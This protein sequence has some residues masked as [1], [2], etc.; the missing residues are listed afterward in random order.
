MSGHSFYDE[1]YASF[2][3]D[4]QAAVNCITQE[5]FEHDS[6][7]SGKV[8][9]GK[10]YVW[11]LFS[12][13]RLPG[14]FIELSNWLETLNSSESRANI[15][16]LSDGST[17]SDFVEQYRGIPKALDNLKKYQA[18]LQKFSLGELEEKRELIENVIAELQL[19][20]EAVRVHLSKKHKKRLGHFIVPTF[21]C[22]V[23]WRRTR[24]N[25]GDMDDVENKTKRESTYYCDYHHPQKHDYNNA[26][27]KRALLS[28]ISEHKESHCHKEVRQYLDKEIELV[29][30]APFL[31]RCFKSLVPEKR[32][33]P[34][35]LE[36][37]GGN[38]YSLAKLLVEHLKQSC[39]TVHKKIHAID[40]KD[41][42]NWNDWMIDGVIKSLDEK[43]VGYWRKCESNDWLE[44][45]DWKTLLKLCLR[46]EVYEAVMSSRNGVGR[47]SVVKI[48]KELIGSFYDE[49]GFVP[50]TKFIKEKT[51][52]S[53]PTI[54][55]AKREFKQE[56]SLLNR[57]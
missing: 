36:F 32:Y 13:V 45:N 24:H 38:W 16:K 20:I 57:N 49:Y 2:E 27:A 29:R 50:K 40:S 4:I 19:T 3:R 17:I 35:L 8:R 22:A 25:L 54:A 10:D 41:Y 18:F 23:C 30:L 15:A 47:P 48:V 51:G 21:F 11:D 52:A 44:D 37:D 33:P 1:E 7:F 34:S 46:Y 12:E 42:S 55:K 26:E 43:E 28:Y 56:Q 5:S 6:K 39:P 31:S 14:Y 9:S 53:N